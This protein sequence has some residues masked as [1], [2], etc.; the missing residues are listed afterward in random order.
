MET[1]TDCDL[2]VVDS[3]VATVVVVV[4]SGVTNEVVVASVVDSVTAVD[5]VGVVVEA[6][7]LPPADAIDA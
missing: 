7:E 2:G 5:G 3:G 4:V 6:A 1:L